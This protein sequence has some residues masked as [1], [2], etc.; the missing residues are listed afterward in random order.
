MFDGLKLSRAAGGPAGAVDRA[1]PGPAKPLERA[2][3]RYIAA[4]ADAERM[5]EQDR[6]ILPH[7]RVALQQARKEMGGISKEA[8]ADLRSAMAPR[9]MA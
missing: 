8:T 3:S 7:Q 6:P 9:R 4:W 1:A 5:D 2:K